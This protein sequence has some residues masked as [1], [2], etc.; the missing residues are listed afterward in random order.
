MTTSHILQYTTHDQVAIITMNRPDKRNAVNLEMRQALFAAWEEFENDS[1]LRV[2]ILTGAGDRSFCAGRD[3][4]ENNGVSQKVFLPILGDNVSVTKPVIA[5]VNGSALGGGWFFTQMCDLVVAADHAVFGMPESKVG[6]APAWAAWLHGVIPQKMI[7]ELLLTGD[8]ISAQRAK[9]IGFV[10][11]VVPAGELMDKAMQL[12]QAV[13]AT[14]P[15]SAA[16][17]KATVYAAAEM[18]RAAALQTA[19][20]IM[21]PLYDSEDAKE[22]MRAFQE[23]RTPKWTGR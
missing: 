1:A 12:A 18:G 23:K 4:S 14:A 22:G 16:A 6:R 11:H 20:H 3:L 9:E 7:M 17:C 5:A 19:F 13:V 21:E 8:P 10:N 2:A 15:L